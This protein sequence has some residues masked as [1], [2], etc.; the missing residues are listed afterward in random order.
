MP[1]SHVAETAGEDSWRGRFSVFGCSDDLCCRAIAGRLLQTCASFVLISDRTDIRCG[2]FRKSISTGRPPSMAGPPRARQLSDWS[3]IRRRRRA[4]RW[5]IRA[6]LPI[7]ARAVA[8]PCALRPLD[9]RDPGSTRGAPPHD[10]PDRP[11]VGAGIRSIN[12]PEPADRRSPNAA[13]PGRGRCG[14]KRGFSAP[15]AQHRIRPQG[16]AD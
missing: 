4:I 2:N 13:P 7:P 3:A 11:A 9:L 14:R 8:P 6:D 10:L 12:G 1:R 5:A 15:V 16:R